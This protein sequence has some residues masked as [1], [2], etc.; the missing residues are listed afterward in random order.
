MG[1]S[2]RTLLP[3][4]LLAGIIAGCQAESISAPGPVPVP[5]FAM[6]KPDVVLLVTGGTDGR[7]EICDCPSSMVSGLARRSGLFISYRAAFPGKCLAIDTGDFFYFDPEDSRNEFVL[8]GYRQ[9]G[10]DIAVLGEQEA[11]VGPERLS[12]MLAQGG[13]VFV[14]SNAVSFGPFAD[15][16]VRRVCSRRF[17]Q[18]NIMVLSELSQD[19]I[20][21]LAEPT[22][23]TFFL[24][25]HGSFLGLT[26]YMGSQGYAPI[27]VAHGDQGQAEGLAKE[28]IADLIIRGHTSRTELEVN[29]SF[30]TPIIQVGSSEYV[31]VV[32]LK[33]AD[34]KITALE[35]RPEL[36][37]E[38][39]PI[40][41]RMV[42]IFRDYLKQ[43]R[44]K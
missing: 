43:R 34:G 4:L 2:G 13:P 18:A 27:V 3:L 37:D 35:Y 30:K 8:K 31:G 17:D 16:Y 41:E 25:P 11:G 23:Y 12:H 39:W 21:F 38:R 22:R 42:Q 15:E 36:V 44:D 5:P 32:A 26:K 10:Y 19:A 29:R 40:D 7:L 1:I 20:R 6:G 28:G 9:M 14:C 24:K 33:I